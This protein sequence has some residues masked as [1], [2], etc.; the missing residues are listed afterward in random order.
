[1]TRGT[2][3]WPSATMRNIAVCCTFLSW[4]CAG[5]GKQKQSSCIISIP[6]NVIVHDGRLIRDLTADQFTTETRHQRAKILRMRDD[7]RPRRILL[8]VDTGSGVPQ[9]I[10]NV[11]A[12]VITDMLA[13]ARPEDSFALRTVG[14]SEK[15]IG[16]GEARNEILSVAN[17]LRRHTSN[18][19]RIED[20]LDALLDAATWFRE[21]FPGDAIFMMTLGFGGEHKVAYRAVEK[22][23]ATRHV[24]LF[25]LQFA[26]V[27]V[28]G[29]TP[30]LVQ[31]TPRGYDMLASPTAFL[32]RED[33]GNMSWNS[34]GYMVAENILGDAQHDF[35]VS[36]EKLEEMKIAASRIQSAITDMYRVDMEVSPGQL[37]LS[38]APDVQK[39]VP[40]ATPIYPRH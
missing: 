14:P 22:E 5:L 20:T 4:A 26:P 3:L 25:S 10:R 7:S 29:Y 15:R 31:L 8:L 9:K 24:R 18:P 28:G 39:R 12:S 40:N 34:G 16:F 33:V 35:E 23:L 2:K 11:E 19:G 17:E 27:V 13:E 1:M 37:K 21:P 32:N 36:A 6:M 38:L 30:G